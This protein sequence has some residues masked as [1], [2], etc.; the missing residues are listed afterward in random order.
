MIT[1]KA[2]SK[3]RSA[4]KEERK[5]QA[6]IGKEAAER[7]L[8]NLKVD[9]ETN[10]D[11]L[12][13][14]FGFKSRLDLFSAL[15][16]DEVK[17]S[18]F[19]NFKIEHNKI[20]LLENEHFKEHETEIGIPGMQLPTVIPKDAE[21]MQLLI[22]GEN[23][24]HYEFSYATCCNPMPGDKVFAYLTS[25]AGLKIHRTSC[26]NAANLFSNYGYRIMKAEWINIGKTSFVAELTISGID[27]GPGVIERLTQKISGKLGLSIRSFYIDGNEGYFEGKISLI[28]PNEEY[29]K[30]A[31]KAI[32][33][34]EGISKV[35][36]VEE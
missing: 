7:K 17:L 29:L 18:D 30:L 13:K 14:S 35:R 26:A 23:A 12:A 4:L 32:Q 8:A 5:K 21:K 20:V 16:N 11:I 3:I 19:K 9:F 24:S 6:E 34:L 15:A 2:R 28:V 27:S 31:I 1:S 33:S 25:T 22:G 10:V 36:R